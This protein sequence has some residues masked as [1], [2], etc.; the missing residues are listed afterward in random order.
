MALETPCREFMGARHKFGYGVVR[1]GGKAVTLHRYL[2][3]AG[4]VIP[5]VR[6][7][8]GFIVAVRRPDVQE[9]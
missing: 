4:L 3:E 8:A 5:G 9:A 7:R 6:G 1:R 2:R